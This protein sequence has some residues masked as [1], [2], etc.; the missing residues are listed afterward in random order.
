M[1]ALEDA[2]MRITFYAFLAL[3]AVACTDGG[4]DLNDDLTGDT[5]YTGMRVRK[6]DAGWRLTPTDELPERRSRF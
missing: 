2:L 1:I 3:G 6:A 5:A 4:D